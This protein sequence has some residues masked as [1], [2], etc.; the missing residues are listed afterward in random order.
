MVDL[1]LPSSKSYLTDRALDA[2]GLGVP[3]EN[4]VRH[5]EGHTGLASLFKTSFEEN[6]HLKQV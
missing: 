2:M 6:Y 5:R 1:A 3:K 4:K